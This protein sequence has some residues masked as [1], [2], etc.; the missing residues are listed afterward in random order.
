MTLAAE[1]QAKLAN[2][3][4]ECRATSRILLGDRYQDKMRH[5]MALVRR[6]AADHHESEIQAGARV[7]RECGFTGLSM[8]FIV[9]AVVE[10]VEPSDRVRN[11]SA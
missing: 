4:Y 1:Q 3:M 9:S 7:I 2:R 8:M 5:L 11:R 6:V 10:C